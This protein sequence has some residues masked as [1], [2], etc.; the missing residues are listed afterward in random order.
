MA[1]PL[2]DSNQAVKVGGKGAA[3]W[4]F[5]QETGGRVENKRIVFSTTGLNKSG[6]LVSTKPALYGRARTS[7][8]FS[9][10]TSMI[11]HE[12]C[13]ANRV[14]RAPSLAPPPPPLLPPALHI[15]SGL[16]WPRA[17]PHA[18][19]ANQFLISV[20]LLF[21]CFIPLLRILVAASFLNLWLLLARECIP[22]TEEPGT[23]VG[24]LPVSYGWFQTFCINLKNA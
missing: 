7:E 23:V 11:A 3:R 17:E 2:W 22:S 6:T 16:T 8:M 15:E 20:S 13:K 10:K 1:R 5:D 9:V 18:R 12:L 19:D 21:Y 4:L 14:P 24:L